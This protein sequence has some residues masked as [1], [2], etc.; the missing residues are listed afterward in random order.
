MEWLIELAE[1]HGLFVALVAYVIWD[2]RQREVR[3]LNII[4]TLGDE[5]KARLMKIEQRIFKKASD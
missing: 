5:V 2:S 1:K 3:L 4:D